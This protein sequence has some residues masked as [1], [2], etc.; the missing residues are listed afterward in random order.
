MNKSCNAFERGGD[1]FS[2]TKIGFS[3]VKI[4]DIVETSSYCYASDD[5]NGNRARLKVGGVHV[6]NNLYN[7]KRKGIW[8]KLYIR[9]EVKEEGTIAA[10]LYWSKKGCSNFNDLNGYIIFAYPQFKIIRNN[11]IIYNYFL[12]DQNSDKRPVKCKK[13]YVNDKKYLDVN[14]ELSNNKGGNISMELSSINIF[15][16]SI[17]KML[18]NKLNQSIRFN[19]NGSIGD[20]PLRKWIANLVNEDTTYYNYNSPIIINASKD[21]FVGNRLDRWKFAW[22][23]FTK[24][25]NWSE[26][27]F[28][29][30]FN[31]LNWFGY[32]FYK[33]KTRSDWPHNL[34]LSILLYSGLIGLVV[35]LFFLYK[36]FYYYLKYN[37][38]Y[39]LLFIFFLVT[40]FFSMFSANSPFDPPVM[41]FFVILPFF[42]HSKE[43]KSLKP[44][45]DRQN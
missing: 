28:G 6:E 1:A 3:Y 5:F 25:Y 29:G 36:V 15:S 40:F 42:I 20:D 22:Q 45:N 9:H 30:G 17:F 7:M 21:Q 39:H 2:Q 10:Y 16:K 11:D 37:K 43:K 26:R 24:E 41:G 12:D 14:T 34:F 4:G 27:I 44:N 23:I 33:D 32:Y 38:E 18:S 31:F 8:Q 35:Y 19:H 13:K